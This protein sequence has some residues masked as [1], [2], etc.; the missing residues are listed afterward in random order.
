MF[1]STTQ[2]SQGLSTTEYTAIGLSS[3]ILALIYV[4]SVSLYLHSKKS[5]RKIV[6]EPEISL[7]PGREVSGLVKNNPLLNSSRH[8][9]S[10]TNSGLTESDIGDDLPTSDSEQGFENV[11]TI[12]I[13]GF[14][15]IS[16]CFGMVLLNFVGREPAERH[17]KSENV[18][19]SEIAVKVNVP[20]R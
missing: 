19:R 6:E 12:H 11:S 3:V 16:S 5:K 1:S 13:S 8:F 2:L 7:T 14:D 4:A 20:S 9:E 17:F 18:A 10:D 15:I